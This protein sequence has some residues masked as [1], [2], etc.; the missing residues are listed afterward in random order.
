MSAIAFLVLLVLGL[1][2]AKMCLDDNVPSHFLYIEED[3][4]EL[5]RIKNPINP[6]LTDEDKLLEIT[7][8]SID[9]VPILEA[10]IR[11]FKRELNLT[12]ADA[13]HSMKVCSMSVHCMCAPFPSCRCPTVFKQKQI[14]LL[15]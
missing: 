2:H 4:K 12:S 5:D 6:T 1:T 8:L 11:Q 7:K 15:F 14:V 10:I 3:Q 13:K 9:N